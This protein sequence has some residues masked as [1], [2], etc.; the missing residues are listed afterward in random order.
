MCNTRITIIQEKVTHSYIK[1][2]TQVGTNFWKITDLFS[3]KFAFCS[4][5]YE[6][7]NFEKLAHHFILR[8]PNLFWIYDC[9]HLYLKFVYW[10]AKKIKLW[11]ERVEVGH[12]TRWKKKSHTWVVFQG[13]CK[14]CQIGEKVRAWSNSQILERTWWMEKI[15]QKHAK[16]HYVYFHMRIL[17][18]FKRTISSL[19]YK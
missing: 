6:I 10:D 15:R 18:P 5:F 14:S 9:S 19:K 12:P 13:I 1:Q 16:M 7:K 4:Q 11:N 17:N 3:Q 2:L 8:G